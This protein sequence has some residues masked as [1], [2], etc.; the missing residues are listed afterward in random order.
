MTNIPLIIPNFNQLTYLRN[1]INWWQW[2]NPEGKVFIVDNGS[3]YEP[4]LRYYATVDAHVAVFPENNCIKNLSTFIRDSING[5]F[6]YY[7]ISDPDIMPH[8]AT[9]PNFLDIWKQ[10][11]DNGYHR[12]GFN[13][14][15]SDIPEWVY[16][17]QT[18]IDNEKDFVINPVV[19]E[20][21]FNGYRAPIDTTFAMYSTHNSGWASPMNGQ[22]WSNALRLFNAFHLGW[23]I[24]GDKLNPEMLNYYST[25]SKHTPGEPSAGKNNYRPKQF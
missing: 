6:K 19:T 10:Y 9:P 21:G 24:N 4:L 8:P 11:I 15:T 12:V 2:Y 18:I 23:Y 20:M 5:Q 3:D 22:D 13:L 1:L 14:I 17:K 7:V 16:N 25:A